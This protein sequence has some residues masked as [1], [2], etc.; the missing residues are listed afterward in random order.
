MRFSVLA[1]PGAAAAGANRPVCTADE[2]N[3][4]ASMNVAEFANG[5]AAVHAMLDPVAT[6]FDHFFTQDQ[7]RPQCRSS[8]IALM[9]EPDECSHR[10]DSLRQRLVCSLAHTV[11]ATAL[12]TP[13]GGQG[14]CADRVA[15][16][17][18]VR[19]QD[20]VRAARATPNAAVTVEQ[21]I[22]D[23]MRDEAGA[24]CRACMMTPPF[25][26]VC[27]SV[28]GSEPTT[29]PSAPCV[30]CRKLNSIAT[31]ARCIVGGA[32]PAASDAAVVPP[33]RV[34]ASPSTAAGSALAVDRPIVCSLQDYIRLANLNPTDLAAAT[35]VSL[36]PAFRGLSGNAEAVSSLMGGISEACFGW[37]LRTLYPAQCNIAGDAPRSRGCAAVSAIAGALITAPGVSG[38]LCSVEDIATVLSSSTGDHT[39][40]GEGPLTACLLET[41]TEE[42]HRCFAEE[43]DGNCRECFHATQAPQNCDAVCSV[44]AE[45]GDACRT[46]HMFRLFNVAA[47]CITTGTPTRGVP[48]P[49]LGSDDVEEDYDDDDDEEEEEEDERISDGDEA[50][51]DNVPEEVSASQAGPTD[52]APVPPLRQDAPGSVTAPDSADPVSSDG[53]PNAA[54][55]N[56]AVP[57]AAPNTGSPT[58]TTGAAAG[59]A[60]AAPPSAVE[61]AQSPA[62]AQ[63][64]AA[65]PQDQ[66]VTGGAVPGPTG[67]TDVASGAVDVIAVPPPVTPADSP[68]ADDSVSKPTGATVAAARKRK[69]RPA[70]A[71]VA[72]SPHNAAQPAGAAAPVV[73]PH[74]PEAVP[75]AGVGDGE[76]ANETQ[77]E[78][79]AATGTDNSGVVGPA[80]IVSTLWLVSLLAAVILL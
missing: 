45:D 8:M 63:G 10:G 9:R 38:G 53:S 13:S 3:Q 62:A 5:T 17:S 33:L 7:I 4:L 28:C 39:D 67:L 50:S 2:L 20:L 58:D 60:A 76:E 44:G 78:P 21:S 56:M 1:I 25:A 37:F 23:L 36:R 71:S 75:G 34:E 18:Q 69:S 19:P 15:V 51:A 22:A 74:V 29:A 57:G 11:R 16:L 46:C 68:V 54:A 43:L 27:G 55:P 24:P 42:V 66:S 73:A 77:E 32:P 48:A 59:D 64:V 65:V 49:A 52:E 72:I 31:T 47:H 35:A 26:E 80:T 30:L 40:V 79:D 61:P 12:L 14:A 70:A 6:I 41:S